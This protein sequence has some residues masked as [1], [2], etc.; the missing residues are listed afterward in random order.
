MTR[1]TGEVRACAV[2]AAPV[3]DD[4]AATVDKTCDLL[5]HAAREGADLVVFPETWL[6]GYPWWT[7]LGP[8]AW[9]RPF[10]ARYWADALTADAPE[11]ARIR[12]HA[13]RHGIA[14][15]LGFA[16]RAGGTLYISQLLT[17]TD[18]T[19]LA[20]RRKLKPTLVERTVF[21]EG[22]GRSLG[23]HD[24]AVGRLGAL[25]CWEHL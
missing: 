17:D 9:W 14:L 18:G 24:S 7:R 22:D 12:S 4:P 2:Q 5:D 10:H 11:L 23:V 15:V 6:P 1:P 20:V 21:G 3:V 25:A 8:P 19:V 13:A 16:E